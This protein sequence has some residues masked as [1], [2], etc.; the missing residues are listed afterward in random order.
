MFI[1]LKLPEQ[2]KQVYE[3]IEQNKKINNKRQLF[4]MKLFILVVQHQE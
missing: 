4:K 3:N 2:N 1:N